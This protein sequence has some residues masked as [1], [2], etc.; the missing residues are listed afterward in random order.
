LTKPGVTEKFLE[1]TLEP[2]RQHFG[3]EF[4]NRIPG[5]FTDEPRLRPAGDLHWTDDLEQVFKARW[6]YSLVD[7]IPSLIRPVGNFKQVRHNYYQTLLELFIERWAEPYYEYCAEHNLDFTGHYWEHEWPNCVNVQD[8][9][10]MSAWQQRPGIDC[11]MN[12]YAEHAGAQ[13]GN[14]RAVKELASV[15]NQLGRDRT[16][17]EA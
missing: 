4:G 16:L 9:M 6:G 11:L 3:D 14:V 13:F 15:A 1:L 5:S 8:N 10:A 17:C 2:Y 7:N 12:N